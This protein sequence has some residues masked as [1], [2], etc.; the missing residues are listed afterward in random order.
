VVKTSSVVN[1]TVDIL[2]GFGLNTFQEVLM[3]LGG[4]ALAWR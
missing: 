3:Y 2:G 4:S 1:A